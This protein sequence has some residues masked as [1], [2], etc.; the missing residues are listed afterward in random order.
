MKNKFGFSQFISQNTPILAQKIGDISLIFAALSVSILG[1]PVM[2]SEAGFVFVMPVFL[3]KIAKV[4]AAIGIFGK[5]ITKMMGKTKDDG[6]PIS[7]VEQVKL[8]EADKK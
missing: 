2:M 5:V 4:S 1:F 7:T 8:K 3:L 6:S